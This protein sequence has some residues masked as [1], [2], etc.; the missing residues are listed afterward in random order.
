MMQSSVRWLATLGVAFCALMTSASQAQASVTCL[1]ATHA[2]EVGVEH[3][4]LEPA[5]GAT[6]PAGTPV[7]FSAVT[8]AM[9]ISP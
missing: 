7:V 6:V 5:N 4:P 9:R 1:V 2:A 3:L 8:A